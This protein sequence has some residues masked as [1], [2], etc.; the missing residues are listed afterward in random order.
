MAIATG[1]SGTTGG[2]HGGAGRNASGAKAHAV[3]EA[4]LGMLDGGG[5]PL[6]NLT[7]EQVQ[8]L[9]NMINCE[10]RNS[11]SER[12]AGESF[13]MD[14]I[15]DTNASHHT[16]GTL[17]CLYNLRSI[18]ECLVGLPNGSV[19]L[20]T[21]QGDVYLTDTRI[22]RDVLFV[23]AFRYNLNSVSHLLF[24]NLCTIQFTSSLCAIQDLSLGTLIGAGERRGGIYYFRK[25]VVA[26][27][28]GVSG[29]STFDLWDQRLGHPSK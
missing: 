11:S 12:M 21:Q 17:S 4:F 16:T 2:Y 7:A 9:M 29:L 26:Q 20:A 8:L 28:V 15:I 24:D 22:L 25:V 1:H 27:V 18:V 19:V 23:P 13:I 3:S 6:A 5:T 14:W 10:Q